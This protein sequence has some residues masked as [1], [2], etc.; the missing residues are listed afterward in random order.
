[1]FLI[2]GSVAGHIQISDKEIHTQS[3]SIAFTLA[4]VI[5]W[6]QCSWLC[7]AM[8]FYSIQFLLLARC[9]F[10]LQAEHK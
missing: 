5:L 9:Y 8:C 2:Q 10:R 7:N 6:L 4:T 3:M 1:M